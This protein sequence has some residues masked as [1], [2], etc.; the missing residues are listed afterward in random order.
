MGECGDNMGQVDKIRK[1]HKDE[2]NKKIAK[3]DKEHQ[4][5]CRRIYNSYC[6]EYWSGRR[7][8]NLESDIIV[9]ENTLINKCIFYLRFRIIFCISKKVF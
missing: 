9:L 4:K 5:I 2:I 7:D 8:D 3:L 6:T 1:Q